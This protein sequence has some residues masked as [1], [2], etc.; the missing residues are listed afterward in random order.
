MSDSRSPPAPQRMQRRKW[1]KRAGGLAALAVGTGLYTRFWEPHWVQVVSRKMEV[2]N[3][4]EN[5]QGKRIVQLSDLHISSRVSEEYLCYW[6]EQVQQMTPDIVVITG[7]FTSYETDLEHQ[8]A[9]VFPKIPHG[10][11][12]T[13]GILGNHDYG[14]DFSDRDH[15]NMLVQIA[16]SAG[17]R[18][19]RNEVA[20][21]AG[22]QI[23]GFDDLWAQQFDLAQGLRQLDPNRAAIALTH[24]PDTVDLPGWESFQ[25]WILAGH[26]HGGQCKP[27]FLPPP[28]LP[29]KN[30]LYS[31]GSFALTGA[32]SMYIN[33]GLGHLL[34]VRFN[35][36][37]EITLFEL[38]A[39]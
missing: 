14:F 24:N 9:R 39:G 36:R 28:L 8:A 12:A 30:R 21:I 33:R 32:R 31:S 13:L 15:A 34:Q 7:D 38:S 3:L 1:L 35:A 6:F 11:L 26:T 37:P 20:D 22:L 2:Q 27:P 17:I 16:S 18:M 19:L 4:P 5:W 23:L 25:G 10:S 29:V